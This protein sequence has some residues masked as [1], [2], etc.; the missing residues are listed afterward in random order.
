MSQEPNA[1][2]MPAAGGATPPQTDP[3]AAGDPA[4]TTPPTPPA[5]GDEGLGDAGQ[6][7]IRAER[8]RAKAAER[9]RDELKQRLEALEGASKSDHEK[10]IDAA[11]KT[12][13]AEAKTGYDARIRRSEVKAA[14]A[15]QGINPAELDLAA[16]AGEFNRLK[17][18]DDGDVEGLPETVKAFKASHP[19]LFTDPRQLHPRGLGQRAVGQPQQGARVRRRRRGQPRLRGPDHGGGDTVRINSIGRVTIGDYTKNT[20]ISAAETLTDAQ[21]TLTIDKQKYFNFQI[22]DIDRAQQNPKVMAGAMAEA[23]YGLRDASTSSI[24]ALYTDAASANL[25]GSTGTPKTDL[26]TAS[27]P[28]NYLVDLGVLLD[29]A[30][31]PS[32]AASRSSRPGSRATCSRTPGSSATA[33]R[34]TST[35]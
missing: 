7:A 10:A 22:D 33:P 4:A 27:V 28:Y 15:A 24:A 8:D 35:S 31:V 3:A 2:A 19:S 34:P 25:I 17:V 30:N 32:T 14:L 18:T 20:D 16:M 23:A 13:A 6:R 21:A 9:E 1:G 11:K 29:N 26:A 12:A 5:T